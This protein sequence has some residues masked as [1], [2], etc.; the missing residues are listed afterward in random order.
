MNGN[1]NPTDPAPDEE[2]KFQAREVPG[3]ILMEEQGEANPFL[4]YVKTGERVYIT[5]EYFQIGRDPSYVDHVVDNP[6]VGRIH[7]FIVTKGDQY[8]IIDNNSKNG[9]RIDSNR[10]ASNQERLLTDGC[11][12]DMG[13]EKF[14]FY[15]R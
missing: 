4:E 9:T 1:G 5:K 11:Q 8:Y 13:S 15:S 7:S 14:Y 2:L 6:T 10:I 12:I 3:T